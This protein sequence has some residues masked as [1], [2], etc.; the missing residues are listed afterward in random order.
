MDKFGS[1]L[2][3]IHMELG[4]KLLGASSVKN[5]FLERLLHREC[6]L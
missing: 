4:G 2:D 1:V 3:R 6:L 5:Q